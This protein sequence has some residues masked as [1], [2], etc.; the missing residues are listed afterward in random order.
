LL[1]VCLASLALASHAMAAFPGENGVIA[2]GQEEKIYGVDPGSTTP[3][4]IVEVPGARALYPRWS[5]DGSRIAFIR[6]D[7]ITRDASIW[8]ADADGTDATELVPGPSASEPAW[9]GDGQRLAF[10][11]NRD[12]W[13]VNADGSNATRITTDPGS[14]RFPSWSPDGERIAFEGSGGIWG[15]GE[16]IWTIDPD[17]TDPVRVSH[18]R[19]PDWSP[20][21]DELVIDDPFPQVG[22]YRTSLDG[23]QMTPIT[24]NGNDPAF[25]PDGTRILVHHEGN[26]WTTGYDGGAIVPVAPSGPPRAYPYWQPTTVPPDPG[27]YVRPAGATPMRVPLVPAF[28]ECE[29]P[30]R[31]H[32]SPLAFDACSAPRQMSSTA[33]I[34]T[35]DVNGAASNSTGY[36]RYAVRVGDPSTPTDEADVAVQVEVNDVR[37]TANGADY[38]IPLDLVLFGDITDRSYGTAMTLTSPPPTSPQV[39][40]WDLRVQVPCTTNEDPDVG[41]R[42]QVATTLDA[43]LP[44]VVPEGSRSVWGLGQVTLYDAGAD[45]DVTTWDDN[46]LFAVQGVFVP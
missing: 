27:H 15:A 28:R 44:G 35:D 21:G 13:V 22:I 20:F 40:P 38:P 1:A 41:S 43:A 19:R 34:G 36:V 10:V 23:S 39:W 7:S 46:E 5:P 25:S 37:L 11:A 17:G 45:G 2:W 3:R 33:T 29:S 32:G 6:F 24:P 12:L 31:V 18:G 26:I 30:D 42:C 8:V 16:N 4:V 9:S 14:E